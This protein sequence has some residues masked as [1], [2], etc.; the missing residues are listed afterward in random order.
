MSPVD[1]DEFSLGSYEKFQPGFRRDEKRP[2]ILVTSSGAIFEKPSKYAETQKNLT[3]AP[4]ITSATLKAVSLLLSRMPMMW[5][6]QQSMQDDAIRTARIYPAFTPVNGLKCSH[7]KI[8]SLLTEISVGKTEK[9]SET[10]PTGFMSRDPKIYHV[11]RRRNR[12]RR[13][14]KT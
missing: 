9:I 4:I 5:K 7:G 1:R 14:S 10:Q 2:K 3:F 11:Q 8:S 13:L 6:I 12:L